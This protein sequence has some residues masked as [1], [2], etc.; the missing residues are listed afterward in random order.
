MANVT[1]SV[2]RDDCTY[3]YANEMSFLGVSQDMGSAFSSN[4]Q[5]NVH[6]SVTMALKFIFFLN[7]Y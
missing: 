7:N 2:G 4:N 1:V 3:L 6:R 5:F